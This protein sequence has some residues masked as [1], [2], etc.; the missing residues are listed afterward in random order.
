MVHYK[1]ATLFKRC[2]VIFCFKQMLCHLFGIDLSGTEIVRGITCIGWI[3]SISSFLFMH[4]GLFR[5]A[6][7]TSGIYQNLRRRIENP[8]KEIAYKAY[9][10]LI[11]CRAS[12]R[13]TRIAS[14]KAADSDS[15]Q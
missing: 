1:S 4:T 10:T 13:N 2:F 7:E 5:I 12:D 15:E 8:C 11:V 14:Q 6:D 9:C 3:D